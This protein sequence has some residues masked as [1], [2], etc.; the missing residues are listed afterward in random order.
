[1]CS[2]LSALVDNLSEIKDHKKIDKKSINEL[3]NKFPNT[4]KFCNG[5]NNKLNYY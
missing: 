3:I 5:D 1:M 4:C 2:S